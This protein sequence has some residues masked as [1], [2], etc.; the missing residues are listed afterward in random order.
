MPIPDF[1]SVFIFPPPGA[2]L[3]IPGGITFRDAAPMICS[4][5][6]NG[7][8]EADPRVLVRL[9][10]ATKIIMDTMIPVGGMM[11]AN[12]RAQG[13]FLI[14]PPQMENVITAEVTEA[15]TKLYGDTDVTQS[16]YEIVNNSAY[17]DP[18]QSHDNP[19]IDIGLNANPTDPSDVRRIYSY[20]GLQPDNAIVQ[21]SGKKRYLPLTSDEDYLIVQNIEAI[22]DIIL[23]I[24][25][26]ENNAVDD[27]AKFRQS[28]FE[29]LQSEVKNH[30]MD[31]RNYMVRKHAYYQDLMN[32]PA[33]SM[34]WLRA[35]IAL[36]VDAALRVGKRDLTWTINQM[37]RRAMSGRLYKDT[38]VEVQANVQGGI[39]YFPL[40]VDSV[41][42]VDL[43]GRP[44]PVRSQFFEH[45][46]NGPGMFS[47]S[48]I[49]KDMGDEYFPGSRTTRRKYKLIANCDNVQCLSAIC[50]VRWL[51][52]K[53]LD[54][55]VI[56][57]YEVMRLLVGSKFLE[58]AN[59]WDDAAKSQA[60]AF[61]I[62]EKELHDY[63]V[64]I[65]RTV[66]IQT[67]GFG[68]GDVGNYY[69]R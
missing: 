60:Q 26:K 16:W 7:V 68:L 62:L 43:N 65:R 2:F 22:K 14:L 69:T 44:I 39:V 37:E 57:N 34:G 33:N 8:D 49:L 58:E 59:K 27:A 12:V 56:K 45:L 19:L 23:S 67:Y 53:P 51:E 1:P 35:Q 50:K 32:F 30:L 61:Q 6:D 48:E 38:I 10:E 18:G 13:T 3:P 36:D 29:L 63:L 25:R 20:P 28:A 64:G 24:E 15:G 9:N 66:H 11:S 52:K 40:Y 46:D 47:C 4:V 31:P 54:Q 5:V 55:M 17:F 41:L 21:L 42:A